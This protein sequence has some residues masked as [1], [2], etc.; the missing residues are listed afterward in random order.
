MTQN[1]MWDTLINPNM[2]VELIN[3]NNN[4]L[5]GVRFTFEYMGHSII[6]EDNKTD[7]LGTNYKSARM[8]ML[9]EV[10]QVYKMKMKNMEV[11]V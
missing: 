4:L 2:E 3:T 6:V 11:A 5:R 1:K 9:E 8:R 7:N 10:S